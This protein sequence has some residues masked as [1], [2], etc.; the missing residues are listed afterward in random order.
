MK[1]AKAFYARIHWPA[2][3]AGLTSVAGLLSDP[4][5]L[6]VLPAKYSHALTVAGIVAQLLVKHVLHEAPDA[7]P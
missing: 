1:A 2:V 4:S 3:V 5:M 7:K 6:N